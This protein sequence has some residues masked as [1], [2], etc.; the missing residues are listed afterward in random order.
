MEKKKVGSKSKQHVVTKWF[1]VL[2]VLFFSLA[3]SV[4][5]FAEAVAPPVE[6]EVE[7][8]VSPV[9]TPPAEQVPPETE[10]ETESES[11]AIP[12]VPEA[13]EKQTDS[14][15]PVVPPAEKQ[16]TIK[17]EADAETNS[18][19]LSL[20]ILGTT[21]VH[22]NL[23]D[24]SYEDATQKNLG[25]AKISTVVQETRKQNPNT[26]LIDNGDN[27][28]GTL[29]T[30]DLY[31]VKPD[32]LTQTHP[33]IAAMNYMGYDAMT[34][35]NHEF[36]FGLDLIKKIESEANFPLLSA[37]TYQKATNTNFVKAYQIKEVNGV[38]V[39]I[40]GL[41]I[42]HIPIWD[43]AKVDS[44]VFHSLR[45]EAKKQVKI[46]KETEQVDVIVASIHAGLDN[47]DPEA[48]AINVI[49]E[50]PEI[51]A[52]IVGHDHKDIARKITD[53]N[54]K[55][56]PVGAVQDTGTGVVKINLKLAQDEVTAK[57]AVADSTVE[58]V[59]TANYPA[60]ETLKS[61]T[62]NY[63][64][65]VNN[66]VK[67]PVAT[68]SGDFLPPQEVPGIPEAQLKPTALISL[69]NNVQKEVTGA[70]IS[71]AALFKASSSLPA[72]PVT[73]ANIFD[74]YKYPNTLIGVEI[75]GAQLKQY[76]EKQ[77]AYYNQYQPGDVTISFNQ[78]IRV[79]NYDMF[80][81]VDYK[82]DISK[83]VG[84]RIVQ[85]T[86][87]GKAVQ[88]TDTFKLAINNY[89]YEGLVSSGI[90]TAQ[91]YYESDPIT[92]RSSIVEYVKNKGTI[93]PEEEIEDNWEVIGAD[94]NHYL[95]PYI[96]EQVKAGNIVVKES[97]TGRTPNIESLN[98]Q[99]LIAEGKIPESMLQQKIPFTI[100]HTNDMHGRLAFDAKG[101]TLGMA[102]LKT[103]KDQEQPTLMVDAG[104][105]FQGL[106]I[107]NYDQGMDMVKAMNAV[108]YDAMTVGNH[109]FDFGYEQAM[110]Y[111][112]ALN[113]PI[114]SANVYKDGVRS[115][116]PYTIIE[117]AG[118]KY[119]IIGLTTPETAT[120]THPNNVK[121]VT[122]ADP[123]PEAKKLLKE[124]KGQADAYVLLTHLGV[125][126][127]TP[128]EWR[129]DTLAESLSQDEAL[130][131]LDMVILDGHSHT[132]LKEGLR[133]GNVMLAQTGNYLN[134][135]GMVETDFGQ[136]PVSL[137]ASLTPASSL[138]HLAEDA[139]VKQ[140]VDE[141]QAKFEAGTSEIVIPYN[142][143][144]L[145]G[146]RDNVRARETNLGNLISDS[147]YEYG[148]TGFAHQSD[149]AVINGGGIRTSL[150]QGPITQGDIIA[151]LP[152]GN[153]VSQVAVNGEQVY[154]MFEH[155]LRSAPK[156]DENGK[157]QLDDKG[158]PA[159]GANGGFLQVSESVRIYYDSNK[160]GALPEENQAGQ[161][162][163][164]VEIQNR[165]TGKFEAVDR[166]KTYYVTTNDFLAAGGD[167][168]TMLGGEREEGP[169]MDTIVTDY[170]KSAGT[171]RLLRE[172]QPVDLAK[173][174]EE[175]PGARIVSMSAADF[176][177]MN[178][179]KPEEP[180]KPEKPN[181]NGSG[182]TNNGNG[183]T[184]SNADELANQKPTGS[185]KDKKELPATGEE[186]NSGWLYGLLF[187]GIS[188]WIYTDKKKY[189]R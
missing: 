73:F 116:E 5:A 19:M 35:G 176:A 145:N 59:K 30:D 64:D 42:P 162:V 37:N 71:A 53:I 63:H 69:I 129:S 29:L 66:F 87:Q 135:V 112:E 14:E 39:G 114:V 161:R 68:A 115:F 124:L 186:T 130:K 11:E 49:E 184:G 126:E 60:D 40:L 120:K 61:L 137:T 52:F 76:M 7:Q 81:G 155:S 26:L 8:V 136:N 144:V 90:I 46:L 89:R 103:Y 163:L 138:A 140:I 189:N 31:N 57:W 51:D 56:K 82:I 152:F 72:G 105:A 41:T 50:V 117:K 33:M 151:V 185:S 132:E 38:K 27:I 142:P 164:H 173:Y 4:T 168:F 2:F 20:T 165:E 171:I 133:Y 9:E 118:R 65:T 100:M 128:K 110:A 125:D 104:D 34:L 99:K 55:E 179:P 22:G 154:Q 170:L 166:K 18:E 62:Q 143:Y 107:S 83:P 44:L 113:F 3:P 70:D 123:I 17:Q 156:T 181:E 78:N 54:G 13:V 134:N 28:Q 88:D 91:P 84:E 183:T 21:D 1:M 77:G 172:S 12:V 6:T 139:A 85:L 101:N 175:F 182:N 153:I 16:Q 102:K 121:G 48:A 106:P 160:T 180:G 25:L 36:N 79:Y 169:S 74:I 131:D 188:S 97:E 67:E 93:R 47:K 150:N 149:F 159:L 98:V 174:A 108:G 187:L 178:K 96:I 147:L 111:K 24:Y 15:I 43:G 80:S 45:E 10:A 177:E 23:W 141:A 94:L 127:T 148:Q 167:G 75:N 119:A 146:E 92:L 95:R 58:V 32:L 157:V 158:Q 109:E 122:F 86:Y